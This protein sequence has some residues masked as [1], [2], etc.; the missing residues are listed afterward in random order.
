MTFYDYKNEDA[1]MEQFAK[2]LLRLLFIFN[3]VVVL[4]KE[5]FVIY[6]RLFIKESRAA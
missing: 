2:S 1:F 3:K 5:Y 4:D 6:L